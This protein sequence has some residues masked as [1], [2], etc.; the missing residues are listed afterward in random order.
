MLDG[1][2]VKLQNMCR[3]KDTDIS[4]KFVLHFLYLERLVFFR[5]FLLLLVICV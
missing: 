5:K 1:R 4:M 3:F 2:S